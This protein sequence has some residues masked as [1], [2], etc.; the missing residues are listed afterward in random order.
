MGLSNLATQ[1]VTG[2]VDTT[3]S[4]AND[5]IVDDTI[6]AISD[7]LSFYQPIQLTR[8]LMISCPPID[9]ISHYQ[10]HIFTDYAFLP[11]ATR[12]AMTRYAKRNQW[13]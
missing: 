1:G 10:K 8:F 13:C 12:S 5:S 2:C 7:D 6:D 11:A 9:A 3:I 4:A